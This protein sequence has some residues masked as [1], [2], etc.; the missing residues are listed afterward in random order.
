MGSMDGGKKENKELFGRKI[1]LCKEL[2]S[3]IHLTG[4]KIACTQ[5][6]ITLKL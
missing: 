6:I 4:I 5:E 3:P 1:T 2:I